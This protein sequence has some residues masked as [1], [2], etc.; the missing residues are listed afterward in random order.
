[1]TSVDYAEDAERRAVVRLR[2][3]DLL[4][5]CASRFE[6]SARSRLIF[7]H[8]GQQPFTEAAVQTNHPSDQ[9]ALSPTATSARSAA[10]GSRSARAQ[11][12]QVSAA[13]PMALGCC[14]RIASIVCR[15]VRVSAF[16]KK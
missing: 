2:L 14:A 15:G 12:N 13:T 10:A 9:H 8:T 7:G 11:R 1:K 5:L 16:Q 6:S 3:N 4:L